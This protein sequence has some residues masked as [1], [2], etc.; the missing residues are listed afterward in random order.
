MKRAAIAFAF[1]AICG[2]APRSEVEFR[3]TLESARRAF[4][5]GDLSRAQELAERGLS[6]TQANPDSERA[7]TFRLLRAE[8]L[9]ERNNL[10]EAAAL[11][12][13]RLP[14]RAAFD[15][16]R[17]RQAYLSARLRVARGSMREALSALEQA[18]RYVSS[19]S[20]STRLDVDELQG[21]IQARMGRWA[22]AETGLA[23]AADRAARTGD[24]FREAKALNDLGMTHL[25]QKRCDE[26]LPW[27]ER[28][29]AR[30]ELEPLA[31]YARALYNAGACYARL[32]QF[33]KAIDVQLRAVARQEHG[34]P[35]AYEQALGELGST[36]FLKDDVVRAL[37]YIERAL[38]IATAAQVNED[39]ALWAK[40]LAAAHADL[41]QW[42]EAERFNDEARRLNPPNRADRLV[43]NTLYA[44]DIAAGRGRLEEA[45]RLF[46]EAMTAA[47][48]D[49]RVRWSAN[50]GLAHVSLRAGLQERAGRYF[51]AAL[52]IIERTRSDLLKTDY[53]LSF[54]TQLIRFH[55]AYVDMLV[56][57]R[58]IE[59]ALEVADSSHGRVLAER[60]GVTAPSRASAAGFRRVAGQ[61][62]ALIL[63]F[64]LGPTRSYLW[65]V[66][67]SGVR[68]RDL[69]PAA[70]IEALVREH[71]AAIANSMVDPL[72]A[73]DTAGDRLYRLLV[74]PI[75]ESLPQDASII[76]VPDGV[77]HGLNFETLPVKDGPRRHYWLEDVSIQIAPSL[78]MLAARP[79]SASGARSVLI[80]GNATPRAPE[81][82]ALRF[83]STEMT[84]IAGHFAKEQV[85]TYQGRDASPSVYRRAGADQF[86]LVH[87]TAHATAN[88]VS[89]LDS[90]VI[91]AGPE[92]AYK[93]Y[94][95]DV[96]EHPL[97]AELVTVS[98][99]KSAG[100]R[101]YSG[102]GLVGFAWAFLRAGA[103][104]VIAG[105]WDVDDRSTAELM[106]ALYA[107]LAA[108]DSVPRSLREAKLSLLRQGGQFA[109]PYYWGPFE[110]FT[111][112]P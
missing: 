94:A 21:Q 33:E 24:G 35:T 112:T 3:Q 69:P 76:I 51:E 59:R 88:V 27:F 38:A 95:R 87:F 100:E 58:A 79:T 30:P 72:A 71:Q 77:L 34:A 64:W 60:S 4:E 75:A 84:K 97:H 37:P 109:K 14:D 105:L 43:W 25:V 42:D 55:R 16:L 101:A 52:D 107:R 56:G 80:I 99:C 44:A 20:D 70:E 54:L 12:E 47:R 83:A 36:Y 53:R 46:N 65:V 23:Q 11:L 8:I 1:F 10:T 104:R 7:W 67:G 26:A 31:H 32:G 62:N 29:L 103:R 110:L 81:F 74:E 102:E 82:P 57:Q 19:E 22:E 98:A 41:G 28:V 89:P 39:A 18:R 40:N 15:P 108:G 45:T 111:V 2:C 92:S 93:L 63:S 48:D 5:R 17:G 6:L 85:T 78:A 96:A 73:R 86:A 106:N 49:P 90:A 68:M 66:S 9:L 13:R 91:L 61:S 50:E